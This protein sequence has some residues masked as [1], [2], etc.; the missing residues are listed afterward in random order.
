MYTRRRRAHGGRQPG[1]SGGQILAQVR[2]AASKAPDY[3]VFNGGTNDAELIYQNQ[4]GTMAGGFDPAT[5]DNSTY[6]GSLETT[7][8]TMRNK[9]PTARIVYAAV[10][11]S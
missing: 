9:R 4:V 11:R 1:G 10:L 6:A 3:V 8:W 2:G 7:I 5:F